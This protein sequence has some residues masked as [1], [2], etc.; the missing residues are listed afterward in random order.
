VKRV[1]GNRIAPKFSWG[2][3]LAL[4][5]VLEMTGCN[6][7]PSTPP[8]TVSVSIT[9]LRGG[10]TVSQSLSFTATLQ[11]DVGSVGVTW[12]SSGG[13]SFSAQSKNSA[14]YV[15]PDTT[16]NVTI[17]ATSVADEPPVATG[18]ALSPNSLMNVSA[19]P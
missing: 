6:S 18:L 10:M 5:I 16:G 13:G 14:T 8:L 2:V 17:T 12:S 19:T 9:P 15:A 1:L 11:N 3:F 7:T 4:G